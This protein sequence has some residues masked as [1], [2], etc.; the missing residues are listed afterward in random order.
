[1]PLPG[2]KVLLGDLGRMQGLLA[3][4]T[5]DDVREARR[6]ASSLRSTIEARRKR[7]EV[8]ERQAPLP[9]LILRPEDTFRCE[10]LNAPL[11]VFA[12]LTRRSRV[13]PSGGGKGSPQPIAIVCVGCE[14]GASNARRCDFTP[15]PSTL[16]REVLSQSQRAAQRAR[17]LVVIDE[18]PVGSG[19]VMREAAQ[20]TPNDKGL[21]YTP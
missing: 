7:R 9:L 14:L 10:R 5:R 19:D 3:R 2:P 11:H 16:P 12:C 18:D 17:A 6:I 8:D 4:G 1:M 21:D 13:W 15:P 20:A